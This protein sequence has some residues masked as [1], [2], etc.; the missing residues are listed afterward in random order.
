MAQSSG[1]SHGSY[2]SAPSPFSLQPHLGVSE[3]LNSGLR[4][5]PCDSVVCQ[6]PWE[7]VGCSCMEKGV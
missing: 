1:C 7:L 5:V 2:L 4:E 6:G 3:C